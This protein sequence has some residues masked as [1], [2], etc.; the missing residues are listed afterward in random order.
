M[1]GVAWRRFEGKR[2]DRPFARFFKVRSPEAVTDVSPIGFLARLRFAALAAVIALGACSSNSEPEPYVEKPVEPLYNE[3]ADALAREKYNTAADLFLEVERQH[4][5]SIWATKAQLMAA[6]AYYEA[7]KY[8]DAIDTAQ[9]FISLHPGNK[10]AAY[11]Y[12][13]VALCYYE[14]IVDV[15]RDQK[16]TELALQSLSE[17]VRRFPDTDYARDARLKL[18]LTRDHLAGKEMEVGRYYQK[19]KQYLA[20]INRYRTVIEKYQTTTHVPEALHRLVETYLALGLAREAQAAG[21]VL[22]YNYPGSTWYQ[23]SYALLTEAELRPLRDDRSWITR[24]F[25]STLDTLF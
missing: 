6:F 22:G 19:K 2:R 24:A 3:A 20:A 23:D 17:V 25:D 10:D 8:P 5:Y 1:A 13:L 12:Y 16:N 4:P 14:Q 21:A 15:G 7:E 11:A 18:D 9:R